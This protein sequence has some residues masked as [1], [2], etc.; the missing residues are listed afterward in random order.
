[1]IELEDGSFLAESNAVLSRYAVAHPDAWR[2]LS[3][4]MDV[5]AGGDAHIPIVEFTPPRDLGR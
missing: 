3:S 5:A 4:A 2:H 1:M